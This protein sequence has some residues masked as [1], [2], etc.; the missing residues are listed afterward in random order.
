MNKELFENAI[1]PVLHYLIFFLEE[2]NRF[3]FS[4]LYCNV[5]IHQIYLKLN[6]KYS[7]LGQFT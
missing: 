2:N 4:F 3:F 5:W 6:F 7:S 1:L